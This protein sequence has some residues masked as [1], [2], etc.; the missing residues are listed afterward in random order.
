MRHLLSN[1]VYKIL[2]EGRRRATKTMLDVANSAADAGGGDATDNEL[3]KQMLAYLSAGEQQGKNHG[4]RALL[5][6]AT[7]LKVIM[8]T[9]QQSDKSTLIGQAARLLEDYPEHYGLH[10]IQAA[11]YALEGD[12][13]NF[14]HAL[15][16]MT[17]FGTRNY[18][19]TLEECTTRFITF[20]NSKVARGIDAETMNELLPIMSDCFGYDENELLALIS[21]PQ[22]NILEAVNTIFNIAKT[23]TKGLQWIRTN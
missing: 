12:A 23:A 10:F 21:T 9:I 18:G 13:K 4:I 5:H 16:S 6:D 14:G 19:L 1:F 7:N 22:A 8:N 11:V 17:D 20:L 2:E 15:R 3:R